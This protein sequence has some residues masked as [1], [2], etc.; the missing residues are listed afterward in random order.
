MIGSERTLPLRFEGSAHRLSFPLSFMASRPLLTA[1]NL[2]ISVGAKEIIRGI[3]LTIHPG[4]VHAIM[5][6]NGSGKSTLVQA[7]MGAPGYSVTEGSVKFRG[8]DIVPLAPHERAQAGLFLAF[9]YPREVEG[10]TFRSFLHAA[11]NAQMQARSPRKRILSPILFARFLEEKMTMLHIAPTLSERSVNKGFSGGEKKKAE[12]LQLAVFSPL[13]SLLDETDSGLDTDALRIVAEG[14]ARLRKEQPSF[15]AVV[16]THHAR[17]LDFLQP[18]SVH[19][20]VDGRIVKSGGQ[21][22]VKQLEKEG[23]RK[24][25]RRS[26]EIE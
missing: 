19:V 1:S 9:Q 17:L 22:L 23:Y 7:L 18:D 6:P 3:D 26:G 5:G 24:Y 13:L 10:V 8:K 4:E 15:A 11:Y 20:M 14:L 2:H 21:S 25:R 12:I 16:V